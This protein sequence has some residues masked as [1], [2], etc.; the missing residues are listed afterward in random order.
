MSEY[1]RNIEEDDEITIDLTEVLKNAQ[2]LWKQLLVVIVLFG[3]AAT[4]GTKFLM[5][6]KYTASSKI[7]I[8]SKQDNQNS[9]TVSMNDIQVAQKLTS[10][11]TKIMQSE[12]ISDVVIDNLGLE[13]Y[14]VDNT[15]YNEMVTVEAED[16][17][18]V[19]NVTA[20][21]ENPELSADLAN[22]VVKVFKDKIYDI[23]SVENITVLNEASVP[24][25][26]SSPSL[27]KNLIIGLGLGLVIDCAWVFLLTIFDKK[28]KSEEQIKDILGY[29][30]LGTIPDF[31]VTEGK[32]VK[33]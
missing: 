13:K 6:K 14:D 9:S 27:K 24:E 1:N 26:P 8:V 17:T 28:V 10:T 31:K 23:M 32:Q 2:K 7:I 16:S 25:N 20:T 3:A 5:T 29:P 18:E 33:K 19:M 22:E 21:T 15:V 11:Y 4:L 30:V 12:A